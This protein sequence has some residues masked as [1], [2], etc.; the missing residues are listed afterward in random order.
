MTKG[1]EQFCLGILD[2]NNRDNQKLKE[3]TEFFKIIK[4]Y[5]EAI[6]DPIVSNVAFLYDYDNRWSWDGQPQSNGLTIPL[7]F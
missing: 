7:N 6:S 4:T 1:A 3:V 5:E 2:A